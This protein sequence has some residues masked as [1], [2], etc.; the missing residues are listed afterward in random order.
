[1]FVMGP[2]AIETDSSSSG[3][4]EEREPFEQV[5]CAFMSSRYFKLPFVNV[6]SINKIRIYFL[7]INKNSASSHLSLM[8]VNT[9]RVSGR[10]VATAGKLDKRLHFLPIFIARKLVIG[11]IIRY[12][13]LNMIEDLYYP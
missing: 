3:Q 10:S 8:C 1:M 4:R 7:R 5:P 12:V 9:S 6:K 13:S 2:H 11:L